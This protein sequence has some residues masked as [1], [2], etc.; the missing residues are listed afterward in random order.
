MADVA[1]KKMFEN[2]RVIVWEML[3]EPG[4]STG[5]HT[6]RHEYFFHVLEG[7]TIDTTDADGKSTGTLDLRTDHTYYLTLE[8]DNL[9]FEGGRVP[10]THDAKNV[11]P[12][13]YREVLVEL[14]R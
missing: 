3:L 1:T 10:A 7:S 6:H 11:G 13:R 9:V 2:E 12:G 8:G 4:E 5:V 14:K